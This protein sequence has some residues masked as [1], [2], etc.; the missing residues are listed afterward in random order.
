MDKNNFI[1]NLYFR[2]VSPLVYGAMVYILVLLFNDRIT[3]L[4]ANFE[5]FELIFCVLITYF[6]FETLRIFIILLGRF[7]NF[8]KNMRWKMTLQIVVSASLSMMTTSLF[9]S[10]YFIYLVGFTT[11]S[12]ELYLFNGIYFITSLLYNSLYISLFYL[13]KQNEAVLQ[14]EENLRKNLEYRLQSFKNEVNPDLLY[15]SLE[16]LI[17]LIYR[18]VDLADDFIIRLAGFYRYSLDNRQD[19][20]ITLGK[21]I[22]A[23]KNL[24]ALLNF[25]NAHITLKDETEKEFLEDELVPGT[26]PLLIHHLVRSSIIS[27]VHPMQIR[28]YTEGEQYISLQCKLN[29][30]LKPIS[31]PLREIEDLQQAYSFY[32]SEALV[33]VKAYNEITIRVPLLK[34]EIEAIA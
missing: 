13:N 20:L 22:E 17:S 5:L 12:K 19:E 8:K 24:I 28:I 11:F 30:K 3:E 23:G 15:G 25:E 16:T 10:A 1:N 7:F 9:V 14:K 32:T 27:A 4:A 29:E 33:R 18:D 31:K 6:N 2:L 21:D 34:L 26:I